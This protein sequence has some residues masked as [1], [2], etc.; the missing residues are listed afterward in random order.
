MQMSVAK[1]LKILLVEDHEDTKIFMSRLLRTY[2]H[3]VKT[4][5]TVQ[6]ALALAD[7]NDFDL[8]I[9][10]LGLPDGDG[11]ALMQELREKYGLKGIAL[12]GYGEDMTR[13]QEVGFLAHLT[14]PISFD[15]LQELIGKVAS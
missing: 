6:D 8:V 12:S 4:A 14:K 2:K 5:G 13:G 7:G 1:P 15:Q 3:D 9:S 11:F 10:D